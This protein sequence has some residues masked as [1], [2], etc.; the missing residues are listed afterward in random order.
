MVNQNSLLFPLDDLA[1]LIEC[2]ALE[3]TG[4][5][6]TE[7]SELCARIRDRADG[8]TAIV[9]R[10]S[11]VD[12]EACL[13]ACRAGQN[14]QANSLLMRVSRNWWAAAKYDAGQGSDGAEGAV[15]KAVATEP[16][17]PES[18]HTDPA[19]LTPEESRQVVRAYLRILRRREEAASGRAGKAK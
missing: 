3:Y 10:E 15:P 8:Y 12:L 11:L 14:F 4:E 6:K 5:L 13:I 7:L 19:G 1:Y 18:A 17:S 2:A 16:Q 9:V